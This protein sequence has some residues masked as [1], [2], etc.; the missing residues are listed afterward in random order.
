MVRMSWAKAEK[1]PGPAIRR[2][3]TRAWRNWRFGGNATYKPITVSEATK[4]KRERTKVGIAIS[5]MLLA[6][7]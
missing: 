5:P 1:V 7:F 2:L 3:M 6:L 4:D